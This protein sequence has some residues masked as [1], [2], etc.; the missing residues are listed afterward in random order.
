MLH[1]GQM[2][3]S[4]MIPS[5]G[6]KWSCHPSWETWGGSCLHNQNHWASY[7]STMEN[8]HTISK[9]L[10]LFIPHSDATKEVCLLIQSIPQDS[11]VPAGGQPQCHSMHLA[12]G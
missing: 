12:S 6:S 4:G 1:T 2:A 8:C 3:M 10:I 11:R 5:S 9:H 7:N